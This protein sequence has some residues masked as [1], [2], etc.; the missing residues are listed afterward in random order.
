[1]TRMFSICTLLALVCVAH[2]G[3]AE[4]AS[5]SKP[6]KTSIA[7]VIQP[8]PLR[9]HVE[10]LASPELEGRGSPKSRELAARYLVQEFK[11]LELKPLWDDQFM[12]K[13]PGPREPDGSLPIWG[14]NVGGML[15]G[16]DPQLRD[17]IVI[18][19]AHY[20][21]LG[22]R[23]GRIYPGADDNASSVAMMLEVARQFAAGKRRPRRSIAF[24]GFD[25]EERLLWGSKWFAAHPPWPLTRVKLFITADL[26]GRTLGDLPFPAVFVMGSEH[27]TGMTSLLKTL[28]PPPGLEL[29]RLGADIVG[30]RSDYGPFRDEKVPFLFFST[31][32][33]PDYHSPQDTADKLNY[34]QLAAISNVVLHVMRHSADTATPPAWITTPLPDLEEARTLHRITELLLQ[35]D[36]QGTRKLT[37]I[38]NYIVTQARDKMAQILKKG[39]LSPDDR[40]W[41]IRSAQAM[42]FSVF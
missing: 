42:L 20:D 16:T 2:C 21:H 32:E 22:V 15:V 11:R 6:A 3:F 19:G 30:T 41:L 34:T 14:L 9:K 28:S 4:D 7:S 10:Y 33:H 40:A 8:E 24:V 39:E 23:D 18:L 31:G 37:G 27:G 13:V 17:E 38:Q 25:L 35:A 12:Q 26:L 1:M 5:I 29:A 36:R